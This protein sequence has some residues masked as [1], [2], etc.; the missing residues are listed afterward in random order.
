V[1]RILIVDPRDVAAI[2]WD[3]GRLLTRSARG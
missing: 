1:V 2:V 3:S